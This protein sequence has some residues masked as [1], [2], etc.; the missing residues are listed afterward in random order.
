MDQ[1]FTACY[2]ASDRPVVY[3]EKALFLRERLL[4]ALAMMKNIIYLQKLLL[5]AWDVIRTLDNVGPG[6]R[7]ASCNC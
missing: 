1:V 3:I 2:D 5:I 6:S 7:K 4:M